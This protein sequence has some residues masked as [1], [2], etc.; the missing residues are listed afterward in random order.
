MHHVTQMTVNRAMRRFFIGAT[1]IALGGCTTI[2][3]NEATYEGTLLTAAGFDSVPADSPSRVQE[4]HE[5]PPLK[6]VSRAKGESLEY[7]LADPYRCRCVYVGDLHSFRQY[8]RFL[9]DDLLRAVLA[10]PS[11]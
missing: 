1:L 4:L 11:L 9:S 5:I 3:R 8:E 2:H 6:M 10:S 7:R